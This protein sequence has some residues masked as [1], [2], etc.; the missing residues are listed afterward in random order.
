MRGYPNSA[1][2]TLSGSS[3]PLLY[4]YRHAAFFRVRDYKAPRK[5]AAAPSM[6]AVKLCGRLYVAVNAID[7]RVE[8]PIIV[9]VGRQRRFA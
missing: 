7:V 3:A 9:T 2:I 5:Y 8:A 4:R 1:V 6:A